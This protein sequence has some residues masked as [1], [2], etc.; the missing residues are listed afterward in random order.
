MD[1]DCETYLTLHLSEISV[2]STRFPLLCPSIE[3]DLN[4][5]NHLEL[6]E[7]L[8]VIFGIPGLL[9]AG[10]VSECYC[11]VRIPQFW[12]PESISQSGT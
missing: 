11:S 9:A 10:C 8:I 6:S 1:S 4:K 12:S 5:Y 7:L 2:D 3:K